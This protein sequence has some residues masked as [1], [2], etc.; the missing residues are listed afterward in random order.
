MKDSL[1][2]GRVAGVRVGV[3]WSLLAM[4]IL[5]AAGLANN[6]FTY[7]A[8]G[9][10][11]TSYIVAGV[12]TAVGLLVGVLLHEL[13]HAVVARR[14][15]LSVDGITL[16]WM[17]GVTRIEGD[18]GS[19]LN[20]LLVA[21]VGPLTSAAVGGVLWVTRILAG[22]AG[23]GSLLL[24]ALGWLAW[25]NVVLAVFNLIPAA[26]LDGGRVL[27]SIVWMAGRDRWRATRVAAGTGVVLGGAIVL[28][29]LVMAERTGNLYNGLLVGF[30]GWWILASA[31][32]ELGSGA[33]HEALDGVRIADVMRPVGE[34]PGWIT[35]RA[36]VEQYSSRRPGWVWLLRD[37]NGHYAGVLVGDA[38]AAVPY[39]N[40]DLAR[41]LDVGM[42][43][44][45]AAGAAPDEDALSVMARTQGRP[46]VFVVSDGHTLGA[47]L[48][49]DVEA[50]VR[51]SGRVVSPRRPAQRPVG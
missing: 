24:A 41:P 8:P 22:H 21:V 45:V 31:R 17:G 19:P 20:E 6:R 25:I 13:G 33:V 51:M 39:P 40:W 7:D 29:G 15:G 32:L 10:S 5:V 34:A 1:R 11:H 50:M 47:V 2:L 18:T 38:L 27:H 23:G 42:P 37:W 16:S 4:V 35:I 43:M 49:H 46:V 26:P 3:H 28:L 36:F 12:L 44:G 48:P 14:R 30:I 9:H